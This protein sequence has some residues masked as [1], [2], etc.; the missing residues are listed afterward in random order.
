MRMKVFFIYLTTIYIFLLVIYSLSLIFFWIFV[1][2]LVIKKTSSNT[3]D[4]NPLLIY[5]QILPHL[6]VALIV[7]MMCFVVQ[8]YFICMQSKHSICFM[9]SDFGFIGLEKLSLSATDF[10]Q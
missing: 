7:F 9:F 3:K 4:S 10:Y 1:I 2:F 5:W 6:P 8:E